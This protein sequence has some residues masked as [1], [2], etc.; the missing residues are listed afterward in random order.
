MAYLLSGERPSV[1]RHGMGRDDLKT[2][3]CLLSRNTRLE[4]MKEP[5]A[6]PTTAIINNGVDPPKG[7]QWTGDIEQWI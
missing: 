2:K 4:S 1:D 3:G 6:R 7:Y 5:H